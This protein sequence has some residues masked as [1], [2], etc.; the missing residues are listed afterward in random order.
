MP[1]RAWPSSPICTVDECESA[2]RATL[3]AGSRATAPTHQPA[4]LRLPSAP[5]PLQGRFGLRDARG[6]AAA[7]VTS[8]YQ[9]A[10]PSSPDKLLFPLA[11]CRECG[12]EYVDGRPREERHGEVVL[13]TP[14]TTATRAAAIGSTATSSSPRTCPGRRTTSSRRTGSPTRGSTDGEVLENRRKYLPQRVYRR[15]DRQQGRPRVQGTLA[16]FIR[17]PFL[18]CLRCGVSYES[19]RGNDYSKLATLDREG[20][21]SAVSI[22]SE[23]IVRSLR[24]GATDELPDEARK[25][26]TFVDNRQ[27]ASLQAGHF[28]DFIQV[29]QLR[30]ALYPGGQGSGRRAG[31]R[32]R[33]PAD[34]G[35]PWRR[36][37]MSTRRAR[38]R[39]TRREADAERAFRNLVEYRLYSD[40]QPGRRIT[41]PNLEQTGLLQI[42]YASLAEIA[43]DRE[44]W[45]TRLR[46]AARRRSRA[47]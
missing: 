9:V 44:L 15:S 28:N 45:E 12:Q 8:T 13:P 17:S 18:F 5:V 47:P 7:H 26:L 41:L 4:A 39:S 23:S 21:S 29:V 22:I 36:P 2:I 46:A 33:G 30:G 25:L 1:P 6:R 38:M 34:R 31:P 10:A 20:R 3:L 14:A 32:G 43:A 37:S 11:F 27:D 42:G 16:A 40:I 19:T 24:E 35:R